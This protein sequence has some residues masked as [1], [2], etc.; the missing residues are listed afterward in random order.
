MTFLSKINFKRLGP[1]YCRW[2]CANS[3]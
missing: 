2:G 1:T 3:E